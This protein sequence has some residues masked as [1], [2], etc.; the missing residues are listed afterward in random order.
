M[1]TPLI[2]QEIFLLERYSSLDYFGEMRD[3]WAKMLD[4]AEQALR[5]FMTQL[6][7][8]YRKR[9]LSM[10]PDVV[11]GGRVLPNFRS[12]MAYLN[13]GFIELSHGDHAALKMAGGVLSDIKGQTFDYSAEWM[14]QDL[15]DQF[16]HWQG[17]ASQRASNISFTASAG[18]DIGDL[19]IRY[20]SNNRGALNPPASW[21]LYRLNPSVTVKTGEPVQVAG[22]YLPACD[23]SCAQFLYRNNAFPEV[24]EANIGYDPKRM[25]RVGTAPTTWTLVE[26]VA[27]SGGGIPGAKD[28]T[29]Q[30]I[31]L[32]C[33]AGHPCPQGGY[34][35][36][37][38]AANS[39]CHFAQG[40]VM[41]EIKSDYGLTI[42]QWDEGQG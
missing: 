21:P 30:G 18:W 27:D 6:P 11:W 31:R 28:P 20:A 15:Q 41:P 7:A 37:P 23:D 36:T 13:K 4:A 40:V 1:A 16:W 25:Q 26:R 10:Q 5:Q 42:W 9:H 29:A 33:E 35:F 3:A 12:T 39:R 2:P 38:A 22:I 34:W 32:R 19:S 17:V 8:D 24:D 14:A